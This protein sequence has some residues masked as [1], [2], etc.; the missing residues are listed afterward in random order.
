MASVPHRVPTLSAV[1]FLKAGAD[2]SV[3][4]L[5]PRQ[6]EELARIGTRLRLTA[7]TLIYSEDSEAPWV[8]AIEEGVVKSFRELPSGKRRITAFLFARDLFGLAESGRYLNS[9]QAV[10][11]VIVYRLPLSELTVLLKHDSDM[12]FK[13]LVKVTHELRESQRR[14]ILLTRR[15]ASGRLAMFLALMREHQDRE[16]PAACA[17]S[18][19]MS[20]SD[21]AGFLG[22]S[23]ESVSRASAELE[24]RGLVKFENR[25]CV[26]V[27]DPAGLSRLAAA[28]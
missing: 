25:H 24:R 10:T 18:L 17:I 8:F 13:F 5:T 2:T 11:R 4:V 26:R 15:D 3:A 23:L 7:R 22:L 21:I 1:P 9:V 20:R 6:R 16:D 19:P 28:V 14:N 12:Q 27:V